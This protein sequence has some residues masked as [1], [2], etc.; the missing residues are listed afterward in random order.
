MQAAQQEFSGFLTSFNF[1][2]PKLP[3][4]ANTTARP[5]P[6]TGIADYLSNQITHPVRWTETID[7]LLAQGETE[8]E[9]IGPGKVLAGLVKRIKSGS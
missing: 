3:V 8:F 9:E 5:Y 2:S 6:N 1:N 7:Y 4:I